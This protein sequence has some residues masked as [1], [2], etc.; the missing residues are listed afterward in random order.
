MKNKKS[1]KISLIFLGFSTLF[2]NC[3]SSGIKRKGETCE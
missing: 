3:F 1:R 2:Y